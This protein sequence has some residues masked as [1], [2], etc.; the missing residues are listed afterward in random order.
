MVRIISLAIVAQIVTV[1][2]GGC[3]GQYAVKNT[4]T[5]NIRS[6]V[7]NPDPPRY[8]SIASGGHVWSYFDAP[9]Y[10]LFYIENGTNEEFVTQANCVDGFI[11]DL[12]IPPH[13]GQTIL[14]TTTIHRARNGL[15]TLSDPQ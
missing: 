7:V 1:L 12:R 6:V 14:V 8:S 2:F 5:I 10:G 4:D 11:T 13:T 3:S 9:T 15:C